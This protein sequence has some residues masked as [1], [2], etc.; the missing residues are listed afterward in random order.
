MWLWEIHP[1]L[2]R[3]YSISGKMY[4]NWTSHERH[5]R[6]MKDK[7]IHQGSV[8]QPVKYN[9]GGRVVM[10]CVAPFSL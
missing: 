4:R 1:T 8:A 5:R 10:V 6:W 7:E 9:N 3:S 2:D